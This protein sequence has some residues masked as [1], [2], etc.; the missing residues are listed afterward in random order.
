MAPA[1]SPMAR[2]NPCVGRNSSGAKSCGRAYSLE[3]GF[4]PCVGRNSSGAPLTWWA[5]A[6][7]IPVSIR[8]LVGIAQEPQPCFQIKGEGMGFNPCVGRNSSGADLAGRRS[9]VIAKFQSVCWSE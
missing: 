8:V 7:P 9:V 5:S 6:G 1:T 3:C 4:N 2:F